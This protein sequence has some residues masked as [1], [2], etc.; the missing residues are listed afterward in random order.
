MRV[1]Q[2]G[3]VTKTRLTDPLQLSGRTEG[4]GRQT[5]IL[6]GALVIEELATASA[7]MPPLKERELCLARRATL[8]SR[9]GRHESGKH[10]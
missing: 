8:Q 5:K 7:V 4:F 3:E 6:A 2:G 10:G 9:Q 1:I